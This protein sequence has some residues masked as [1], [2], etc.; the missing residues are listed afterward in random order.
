MPLPSVRL[1]GAKLCQCLSKRTKLPCNNPA[2]FG[3]RACRLH[4][5][6]KSHARLAGSNHP[7]FQH[8]NETKEAR[9]ERRQM[10]LMFQRLEE[11][12]WHI[13]LFS[14]SSTK[15]KGRKPKNY[16]HNQTNLQ[17][18]EQLVAVIKLTATKN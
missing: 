14:K 2:A 7:N 6:H 18:I 4:G 16:P 3:S 9:A 12:G 10:S 5:A 8:G 11:I 17:D 13:G 15:L 1:Y